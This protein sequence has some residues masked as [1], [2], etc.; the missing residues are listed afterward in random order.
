MA[1]VADK[2]ITAE[3]YAWFPDDGRPTELVRGRIVTMNPPFSGTA[4]LAGIR[5]CW[6]ARP[7]TSTI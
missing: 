7:W 3:E 4:G 6:S 2:L 1:T 5:S